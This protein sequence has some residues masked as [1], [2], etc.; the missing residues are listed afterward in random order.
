MIDD[1]S[2]ELSAHDPA[3]PPGPTEPHPPALRSLR[4]S[5]GRRWFVYEWTAS[6]KSPTPGRRF[7]VLDAGTIVRRLSD[8]PAGWQ[9]MSDD[10]LL[11][12][13]ER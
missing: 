11:A 4:D 2:R 12:L 13:I 1:R 7:L 9:V 3:A 8:F 5:E 6:D 10:E